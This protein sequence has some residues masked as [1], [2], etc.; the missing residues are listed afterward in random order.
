[1]DRP[2]PLPWK[3]LVQREIGRLLAPFWV[4]VVVAIL[5]FGMGYRIEGVAEVRRKYAQIR[6]A[7]ESSGTPLLICANHLTLIDSFLVAWALSST[8]R[9]VLHFDELPWNVPEQ[10]NFG[11]NWRDRA[12]SW[13][14]KCIPIVR[15]GAREEVAA[16]L[17]RITNLTAAGEVA[18]IFPEGGRSR[19]GRVEMES[20]AWGVGR[21]VGALPGCRVACVYLRGRMQETWS[22]LPARGDVLEAD[23][24]CIEPKS[25]AKG[26][27]R[28][29]DFA[30]Q[31]VA[32]LVSMEG[33]YFRGRQ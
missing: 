27:R 22:S 18:L 3:H 29:R 26:V 8:A 14:M 12:G 5:R 28:S 33:E 6:A 7:H 9:Y 19:S 4:P 23:V 30:R 20:A 32:Q 17:D 15:G 1:M 10:K 24:T 16:V 11:S 31:I 13:V 25:D 21:I 2:R